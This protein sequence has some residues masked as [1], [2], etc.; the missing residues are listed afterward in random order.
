MGVPEGRIPLDFASMLSTFHIPLLQDSPLAELAEALRQHARSE[1]KGEPSF[2]KLVRRGLGAA[3]AHLSRDYRQ[4]YNF[5]DG[6]ESGM[7]FTTN[8]AM[9]NL[10][11]RTTVMR[12]ESEKYLQISSTLRRARFPGSDEGLADERIASVLAES[13]RDLSNRLLKQFVL[14]DRMNE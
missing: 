7:Y 13:T 4:L 11:S 1:L 8:R 6:W 14:Y 10:L 2:L 12:E 5:N 9:Q 3:T